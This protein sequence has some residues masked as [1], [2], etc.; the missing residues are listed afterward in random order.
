MD[1]SAFKELV[2]K[3]QGTPCTPAQA[4]VVDNLTVPEAAKIFEMLQNGQDWTGGLGAIAQAKGGTAADAFRGEKFSSEPQNRKGATAATFDGEK[5][6]NAA[7]AADAAPPGKMPYKEL[8]NEVMEAWLM[9]YGP[10]RM[11]CEQF[12]SANLGYDW[13]SSWQG[14][15]EW[16]V[17]MTNGDVAGKK[18]KFNCT[19]TM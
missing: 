8:A 12:K 19:F 16:N 18:R 7:A 3:K 1:K 14:G 17:A 10:A 6:P 4:Q 2:T 15:D 11:E 9:K 13:K 5:F